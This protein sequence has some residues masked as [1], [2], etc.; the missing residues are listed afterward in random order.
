MCKEFVTLGLSCLQSNK[1]ECRYGAHV[2]HGELKAADK[3]VI[4]EYCSNSRTL[5]IAH[6]GIQYQIDVIHY[7]K[8]ITPQIP[9][10][11][12]RDATSTKAKGATGKAKPSMQDMWHKGRI[13]LCQ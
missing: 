3:N 13:I 10:V 9:S 6:Q 7:S 4:N 5:S 11:P 1:K 2:K 12:P 8:E